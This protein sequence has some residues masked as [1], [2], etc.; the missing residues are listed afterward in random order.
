MSLPPSVLRRQGADPRAFLRGLRWAFT[1]NNYTQDESDAMERIVHPTSIVR[2][3]VVGIEVGEVGT[4]HLQCYLECHSTQRMS[5]MKK[6]V[7]RAHWEVAQRSKDVNVDYCKKDGNYREWG[8]PGGGQ[9][10]RNDLVAVKQLIDE[11]SNMLAVAES[12]FGPFVRYHKGFSLY[13]SLKIQPSPRA[14]QVIIWWWGPT[15][16]GKTTMLRTWLTLMK[17]TSY[18]VATSPTRTWWTGYDGE[19]VV[20]MDELREKW[21]DHEVALR[22][23]DRSPYRVPVHGSNAPLMCDYILVT[24]NDPPAMLY[25][26]DP[27]NA[28]LRRI[29]DYAYVYECLMDRVT[30]HNTP[31]VLA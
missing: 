27:A 21:F 28:F 14:G 13:R 7:P 30:I 5:A 25:P 8:A 24:S 22:I 17:L 12:Y 3:L 11:G 6:I 20:V 29:R 1:V 19:Q 2:Y 18:W 15:G 16:T 31:L 4:P 9:G 23:F 10:A 26:D